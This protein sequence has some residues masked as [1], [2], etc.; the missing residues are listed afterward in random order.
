MMHNKYDIIDTKIAIVDTG[1]STSCKD[2]FNVHSGVSVSHIHNSSEYVFEEDYEDHHGHGT[3]VSTLLAAFCS[4]I[5]LVAVRIAQQ[6]DS[7]A[8]VRVPEKAL[9]LG[10]D[11]C[12]E[13]GIRIINVSYS[14]EAVIEDGL[15][16]QVCKKAQKNNIIIV[17]AY[18]NNTNQLVYP[19]AFSNVIGVSILKNSEHGQISIV[20]EKNHDVAVFGG[21]Y[22]VLSLNNITKIVRGTSFAATQVTGMVGR[23]LAIRPTLS[24][25][26]IFRY[27]KKYSI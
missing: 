20:S 5:P 14:I 2:C 27:L 9:A 18:R 19:A 11:W 10:I 21:P 23:M 16:I 24:F 25:Q 17:A 6:D 4:G 1:V 26:Q 8:I 7:G 3:E 15:L 12:I 13:Q 22:Q